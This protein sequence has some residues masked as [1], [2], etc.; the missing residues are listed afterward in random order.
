M[1]K[2]CTARDFIT[3]IHLLGVSNY[4]LSTYVAQQF[5]QFEIEN[6]FLVFRM[7]FAYVVI[8]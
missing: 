1:I 5:K 3:L 7:W 2:Y 8:L 4:L 6:I